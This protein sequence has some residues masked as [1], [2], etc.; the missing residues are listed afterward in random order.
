MDYVCPSLIVE[1]ILAKTSTSERPFSSMDVKP[2]I[3]NLSLFFYMCPRIP[4][5][6]DDSFEIGE[7]IMR[8]NDPFQD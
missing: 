8:N 4:H 2:F 5:N 6:F 7:L 3:Q 1:E